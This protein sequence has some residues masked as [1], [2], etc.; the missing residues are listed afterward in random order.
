MARF[1]ILFILPLAMSA[2]ASPA[3]VLP[4]SEVFIYN[5]TE[6]TGPLLSE[7]PGTTPPGFLSKR[8]AGVPTCWSFVEGTGVAKST[9][10]EDIFI[11]YNNYNGDDSSLLWVEINPPPLNI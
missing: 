1:S 3:P 6:N 9:F 8:G 11:D 7:V 10:Q 4:S 5:S 2:L